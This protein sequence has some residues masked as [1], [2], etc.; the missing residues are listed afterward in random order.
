MNLDDDS[1]RTTTPDTSDC[2]PPRGKQ[3]LVFGK[4]KTVH[5]QA[6]SSDDIENGKDMLVKGFK[7]LFAAVLEE[8]ELDEQTISFSIAVNFKMISTE[9]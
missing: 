5:K 2:T 7:H 9:V 8:E 1:Q 6:C 3:F 4:Q